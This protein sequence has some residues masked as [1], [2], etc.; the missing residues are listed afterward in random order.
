MAAVMWLFVT[1][2]ITLYLLLNSV[3]RTTANCSLNAF[4]LHM[5]AVATHRHPFPPPPN[6]LSKATDCFLF[7]SRFSLA[8]FWSNT[9]FD[10][11]V[12][13][14][15][16]QYCNTKFCLLH[17]IHI[18]SPRSQLSWALWYFLV[19]SICTFQSA[20]YEDSQLQMG[21]MLSLPSGSRNV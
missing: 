8:F 18:E 19:F 6:I 3:T 5:A 20:A 16:K 1:L 4:F 15:Q 7:L 11:K 9:S 17:G 13:R 21:L 2:Y 12:N 14:C 10:L